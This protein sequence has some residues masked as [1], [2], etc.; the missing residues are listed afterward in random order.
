MSL[1]DIIDTVSICLDISLT[2]VIDAIKSCLNV[3][4]QFTVI[5]AADEPVHCYLIN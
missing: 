1:F 4:L 5:G 3:T 2:L